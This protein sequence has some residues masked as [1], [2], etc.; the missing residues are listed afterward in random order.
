MSALDEYLDRQK[1]A[2]ARLKAI[3]EADEQAAKGSGRGTGQMVGTVAGGI[4]GTY[5]GGNTALGASI[6]GALGGAAGSALTG[7]EVTAGDVTKVAEGIASANTDTV[8][9]NAKP[10]AL[11]EAARPADP[12]VATMS[13]EEYRKYLIRQETGGDGPNTKVFDWVRAA[14]QAGGK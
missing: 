8:S 10:G 14:Y 9:T 11:P 4:I 1:A 12:S 2:K 5:F 13:A 6:G 3:E 7:G